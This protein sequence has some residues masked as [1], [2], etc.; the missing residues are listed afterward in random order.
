MKKQITLSHIERIYL[1]MSINVHIDRLTNLMYDLHPEIP[2]EKALLD[3]FEEMRFAL[4]KIKEK[5]D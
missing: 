2:L 1:S 5:L 4:D 3:K